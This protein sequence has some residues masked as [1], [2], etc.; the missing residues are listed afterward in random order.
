MLLKEYIKIAG[1]KSKNSNNK[2]YLIDSYNNKKRIKNMNYKLQN[3]DKVFIE[4]KSTEESWNNF[5]EIL[6]VITQAVTF[7][8][9]IDNIND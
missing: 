9:V 6:T 1:G 5:K 2:V 3:G 4:E 7:I 8:A